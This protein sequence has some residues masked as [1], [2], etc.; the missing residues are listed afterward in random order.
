MDF[1]VKVIIFFLFLIWCC[2]TSPDLPADDWGSQTHLDSKGTNRLCP[3]GQ[4]SWSEV[5]QG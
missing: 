2:Y 5:I 3:M 1:N 4:R